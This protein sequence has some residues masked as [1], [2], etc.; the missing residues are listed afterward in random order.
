MV[1]NSCTRK[2]SIKL[3]IVH[4]NIKPPVQQLV[5]IWYASFQS[6][7]YNIVTLII[8]W[9]NPCKS[10]SDCQSFIFYI[11]INLAMIH[12]S[13]P[14]WVCHTS[15][16]KCTLYLLR[17]MSCYVGCIKHATFRYIITTYNNLPYLSSKLNSWLN[18]VYLCALTSGLRQWYHQ[19]Q[20]RLVLSEPFSSTFLSL[21]ATL[22][23]VKCPLEKV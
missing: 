15:L 13:N 14:I 19:D 3:W 7:N 22:N 17:C 9:T 21:C 12:I 23:I 1:L 20:N 18:C 8:A 5:Y 11:D 4:T 10:L 2:F 6:D 16:G